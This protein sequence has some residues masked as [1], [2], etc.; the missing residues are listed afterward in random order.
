MEAFKGP[1]FHTARWRHDVDYKNKRI[2]GDLI[3][4]DSQF[5]K[6]TVYL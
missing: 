3:P 5:C 2:V 1:I 6:L 4:K